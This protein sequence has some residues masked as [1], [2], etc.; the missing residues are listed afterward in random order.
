[1]K[2]RQGKLAAARVQYA[3]SQ[4]DLFVIENLLGEQMALGQFPRSISNLEEELAPWHAAVES[5]ENAR[6][7]MWHA[8][9]ADRCG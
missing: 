1:M 3:K 6:S 9:D 8:A 2:D 4:K 7:A 5:V